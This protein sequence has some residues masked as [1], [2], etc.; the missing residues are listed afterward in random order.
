MRHEL[1][2]GDLA[3]RLRFSGWLDERC[4]RENFFTSLLIGDEASFTMNGEVNTHNVRQNAPNGHPPAFHFE[5]S[6]SREHLNTMR[7]RFDY[8]A[9]LLRREC[10]RNCSSSHAQFVFPQLAEHFSNQY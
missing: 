3:R 6:N 9:L 7:Q 1:L 2:A 4:R 5:R 10:K 8:L